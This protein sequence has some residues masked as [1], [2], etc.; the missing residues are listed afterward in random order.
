[1][2]VV[3]PRDRARARAW[4]GATAFGVLVATPSAPGQTPERSALSTVAP[5]S[6]T[7]AP[8]P[9]P[10]ESVLPLPPGATPAPRHDKPPGA[11]LIE[12]S[13]PEP[14]SPRAARVDRSVVR[15]G[16]LD[17]PAAAATAPAAAGVKAVAR[18]EG[19]AAP[20][21]RITL[22]GRGSSGEGLRFLWIQTRGPAVT[23]DPADAPEVS[24]VVPGEA[25]DLGFHLVVAGPGG[26]DRAVLDVPLQLHARPSLPPLVVADAG[27]DQVAVV[28]RRV[29]LNGLRSRPRERLAY[30][31]IQV[32]GPPVRDQH[33]EAWVVS[34]VPTGTGLHRFL[35]VVSADGVISRPDEVLVSVISEAEAPRELRAASRD[36][37][38]RTART[39]QR[40]D[41]IEA[42]ARR[43]L[44][45][46]DGTARNARDLAGAFDAVADRMGLYDAYADVFSE[47][48]RRLDA[49]LPP[50]SSRRDSWDRSV[51]EP[52]SDR[53]V[54]SLRPLDL[55]P[56]EEPDR[57]LNPEQK[58]RL[59][60]LFRSI[61]RGFRAAAPA[62]DGER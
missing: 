45:S 21:L 25:T 13:R 7:P 20:G 19:T 12:G 34:F 2:G 49:I 5:R 50:E 27:D 37:P 51:F 6:A 28:G 61:A 29:T 36:Q 15:A 3:G 57:T 24:F 53:I 42:E 60:S 58:D 32:E 11:R 56:A 38:T 16:P 47:I 52:L 4:V 41:P 33:E 43:R 46:V 23:L 22:S 54:Q 9:R 31:W 40:P 18:I 10:D 55:D 59:V 44:A 62:A 1:M 14:A 48:S 26:V 35:L 17:A 39:S 30:R 8:L